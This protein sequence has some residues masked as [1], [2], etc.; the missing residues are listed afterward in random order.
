MSSAKVDTT[1]NK[2]INSNVNTDVKSVDVETKGK[3][4]KSKG[5][6]QSIKEYDVVPYKP[7]NKEFGLENHNGVMEKW[8]IEKTGG[9]AGKIDWIK[10]FPKEMQELTERLFDLAKVPEAARREYYKEFQK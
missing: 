6:R 8:R 10:V 4:N 9:P 3:A 7:S 2:S 5:T 1:P